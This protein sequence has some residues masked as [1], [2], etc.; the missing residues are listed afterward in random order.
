VTKRALIT[1]V[2]GQDGTYLSE[3]LLGRDYEVWGVVGPYPGQFLEWAKQFEGRLHPIDADLTDMDSLLAA[4]E[5]S[6]P[7]EVYNFAAQSSVGNSFEQAI[8]T[9]EVNAV[10]VLRMLEAMRQ[11]APDARFFQASS[12]EMFG[13]A[14][15]MPQ[16]ET[17]HYRQLSRLL[18]DARQQR[19]P[20]QSRISDAR[21]AV[22]D[23]QD[24]RRRGAL[25]AGLAE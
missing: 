1:G 15:E 11:L 3:L 7:D 21:V 4:V 2:A 13:N 6:K 22:R 8:A 14:A 10:G 9:T 18:R 12:A 19:Y 25:Q 20:V 17:T 23:A 24:H 5:V 16:R